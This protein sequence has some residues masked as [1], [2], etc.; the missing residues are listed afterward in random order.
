[1]KEAEVV[2]RGK[3][4]QLHNAPEPGYLGVYDVTFDVDC[5]YKGAQVPKTVTVL[6]FGTDGGLCP[7]GDVVETH[8]Y[9]I[10]ASMM[11]G[12]FVTQDINMQGAVKEESSALNDRVESRYQCIVPTNANITLN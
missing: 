8:S 11:N 2:F 4:I 5:V 3:V 10:F 1:M 7:S 9:Y 6:N 12:V